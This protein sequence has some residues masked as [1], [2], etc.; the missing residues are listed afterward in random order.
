MNSTNLSLDV[1]HPT[2]ERRFEELIETYGAPLARLV[3][4]YESSAA[5]RQ[6]LLQ[7]IWFAI[8]RAL[9]RFRGDCSDRTFVYRVAHNRAISHTTRRRLDTTDLA[10]ASELVNPAPQ[11]EQSVETA[12]VRARLLAAMRRLPLTQREAV[13]LCLEGLSHREIAQVLGISENNV[14]VRLTRARAE[15]ARLI[16][17]SP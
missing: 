17:E 9:P 13:T 2:L 5:E 8:W 3:S 14:A 11:A 16:G 1:P 12:Q 6:D 4:A 15:L 7:N 10:N